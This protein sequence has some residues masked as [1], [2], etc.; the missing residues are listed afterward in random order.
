MSYGVISFGKK[1]LRKGFELQLKRFFPI[2]QTVVHVG[3]GVSLA[4]LHN[5]L[6]AFRKL[7]HYP[8]G[9]VL[10]GR[11]EGEEL[12]EVSMVEITMNLLLDECEVDDHPILVQLLGLAENLDDPVVTMKPAALA[13][14]REVEV[15]ASRNFYSF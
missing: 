14:I 6:V 11:V 12:V 5:G 15:V 9:N 13:L 4:L 1:T 10:S 2:H 7:F 8:S 3:G